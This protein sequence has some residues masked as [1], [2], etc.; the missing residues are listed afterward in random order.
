[1]PDVKGTLRALQLFHHGRT[2][3]LGHLGLARVRARAVLVVTRRA[4]VGRP[5]GCHAQSTVSER[6][7][8]KTQNTEAN[9]PEHPRRTRTRVHTKI[10]RQNVTTRK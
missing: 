2:R 1:M 9:T 6:E 7:P 4:K 10:R 3:A 5:C 8:V